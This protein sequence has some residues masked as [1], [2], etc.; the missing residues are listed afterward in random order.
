MYPPNF[1]RKDS[2][3]FT[4]VHSGVR[5]SVLFYGAGNGTQGLTHARQVLYRC[6]TS[7]T[8]SLSFKDKATASALIHIRASYRAYS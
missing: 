6:M 4:S 7:T 8:L 3:Q 1:G 2:F 5:L